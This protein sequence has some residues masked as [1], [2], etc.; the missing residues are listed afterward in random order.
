[1]KILVPTDFTDISEFGLQVARDIALRNS[2]HIY[3]VNYIE[4]VAQGGFSAT[5]D[6]MQNNDFEAQSYLIELT[7]RNSQL[8]HDLAM[9]YESDKVIIKPVIEVDYFEGAM[10]KFIKEKEVDLVVM[11]T[12]GERSYDELIFGNHTEKIIRISN[13]PVLSVKNYAGKFE[14]ASMVLAVDLDTEGP[15]ELSYFKKFAEWFDASVHFVHVVKNQKQVTEKRKELLE[16]QAKA[17]G[18]KNYT[19]TVRPGKNKEEAVAEFAGEKKAD[20]IGVITRSRSS[21]VNLFFGSFAEEIVKDSST[22]ALTMPAN[23][24]KNG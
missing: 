17:Y 4:P 23:M 20:L 1:M 16:Q 22:P 5:G 14:P 8:I 21:F 3:L 12:S 24:D 11:G 7:K 13:C 19:T 10:E 18:F 6:T 15:V 2:A 9:K